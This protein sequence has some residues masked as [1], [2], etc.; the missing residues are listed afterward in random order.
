MKQED[1]N[2]LRDNHPAP[3]LSAQQAQQK[4]A[5]RYRKV[6]KMNTVGFRSIWEENMRTGVPFDELVDRFEI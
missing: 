4:D 1:I 6:R 2:D 5:E 3:E